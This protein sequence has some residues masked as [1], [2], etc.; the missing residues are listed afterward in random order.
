[1]LPPKTHVLAPRI[2]TANSLGQGS[3]M[4]EDSLL[5][6]VTAAGAATDPTAIKSGRPSKASSSKF[7][8]QKGQESPIETATRSRSNRGFFCLRIANND[9][10]SMILR[11]A[12]VG[13]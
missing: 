2:A 3:V 9:S 7:C 6:R 8:Q 13:L 10:Y 4:G 12:S 1:M 11:R 5:E